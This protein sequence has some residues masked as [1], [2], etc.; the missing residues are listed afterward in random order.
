MKINENLGNIMK[1]MKIN[2]M[3]QNTLI[4]LCNHNKSGQTLRW[5]PKSPNVLVHRHQFSDAIYIKPPL[6]RLALESL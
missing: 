3:I 1:Y 4:E 5:A 2:E 6:L